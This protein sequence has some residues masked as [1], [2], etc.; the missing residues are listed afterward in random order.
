MVAVFRPFSANQRLSVLFTRGHG[1]FFGGSGNSASGKARSG[2]ENRRRGS[3]DS[4]RDYGNTV[5]RK[6]KVGEVRGQ[7]REL[8]SGIASGGGVTGCTHNTEPGRNGS[9]SGR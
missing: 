4:G 1:P 6:Q 3:S 5:R 2:D 8:E 9:T 7:V